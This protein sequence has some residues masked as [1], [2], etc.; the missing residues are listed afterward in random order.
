MNVAVGAESYVYG[1]THEIEPKPAEYSCQDSWCKDHI[2]V[3]IS[4]EDIEGFGGHSM[5]A[6]HYKE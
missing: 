2:P 6:L 3:L 4:H 1:F 5:C